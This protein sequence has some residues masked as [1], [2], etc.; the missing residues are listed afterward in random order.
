VTAVNTINVKPKPRRVRGRLGK[1]SAFKKAVV[2]LASGG[3]LDEA[4]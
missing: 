2:T 3:T 4:V 1:T